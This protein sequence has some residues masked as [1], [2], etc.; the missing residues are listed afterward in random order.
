MTMA[1]TELSPVHLNLTTHG[2]E[3]LALA[4]TKAST[5]VY[6]V[7]IYRPPSMSPVSLLQR[8]IDNHTGRF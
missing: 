3:Y 1:S 5:L 7:A 8:C 2:L 6:I 4:V